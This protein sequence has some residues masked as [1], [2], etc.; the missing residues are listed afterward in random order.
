MNLNEK[1]IAWLI[2]STRK[3][4]EQKNF[5]KKLKERKEYVQNQFKDIHLSDDDDVNEQREA[6]QLDLLEA[7]H[8]VICNEE[9]ILNN[10]E[11]G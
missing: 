9:R 3:I 6:A 2:T 4:D 5:V 7:Y 11:G 8:D 1:Q 10:Y